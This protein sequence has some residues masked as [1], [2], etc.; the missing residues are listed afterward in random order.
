MTN[1]A[2]SDPKQ[3]NWTLAS[4][5]AR[6]GR[7]GYGRDAVVSIV[8]TEGPLAGQRIELDRE[9]IL[10]R[11][12]CDVTL[13]DHQVS[14]RHLILRPSGNQ[15]HVEDLGSTNGTA[16]DGRQIGEPVNAADGTVVRVGTSEF[17]VQVTVPAADSQR[18]ALSPTPA[19]VAAA[20]TAGGL[21]GWFW[22]VTTLVQLVLIATAAALLVHYAV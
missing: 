5:I 3:E 4:V 2:H 13:D 11:T 16:V 15:V 21:P 18:T 1:T 9:M 8:F 14:R 10:G 17:V 6:P 20:A 19:A 7:A 22:T 12:D